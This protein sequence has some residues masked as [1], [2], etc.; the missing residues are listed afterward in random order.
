MSFALSS[1][2]H[3]A[4]ANRPHIPKIL[5]STRNLNVRNVERWLISIVSVKGGI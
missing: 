5:L 4:D 1:L 2:V 3:I